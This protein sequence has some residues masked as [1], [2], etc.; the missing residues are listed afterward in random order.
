MR[1]FALP[2]IAAAALAASPASALPLPG[3]GLSLNGD[4]TLMTDYRF[5]GISRSGEDPALQGNLIASHDSGFYV[6]A[7]A[8]TLDG[9]DTFRLRDPRVA[10]LGD[11]EVQLYAGYGTNMGAGFSADAGLLYYTFAGSRGPTDHFEPYASL[12][13]LLGPVEATAGL[14]YAPA[15]NGTGDEDMTYIFG[16]LEA[17]IPLT[18]LSLTAHAG[19]QDWGAFGSYWNWSLGAR[20]ALGPAQLGVRYVDTDLP[21]VSGQDAGVVLS[22]RLGF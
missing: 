16:E 21:S 1:R 8:T 19:K 12:S 10:D 6:G 5:R 22:V 7:R 15:Q 14:R 11:A 13:Y 20:Y 2:V 18:P 4:L 17:G 9:L 3:T